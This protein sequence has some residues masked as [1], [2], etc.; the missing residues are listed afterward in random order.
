IFFSRDQH[1]GIVLE[2]EL[3]WRSDGSCFDARLTCNPII[4][5]E[6][7]IGA[8]IA[9]SDISVQKQMLAELSSMRIKQEAIINSTNDLIW[10]VDQNFQLITANKAFLER[11]EQYTGIRLKPGY[12]MLDFN[13]FPE[14]FI[15]FW[16]ELYERALKGEAFTE[17][18]Y[19][20]E[21]KN[22]PAT[23]ADI[24]FSPIRINDRITG[25][26]C[27]SRDMTA[28]KLYEKQILD[29]NSKLETAQQIAQLG[30]WELDL[31]RQTLYWSKEVYHIWGVNPENFEVNFD[32]F[33]QSIHPDDRIDFDIR[34]KAAMK[35]GEVLD[36][37]HRIILPDG[38]IRYVHEK[39]SL[40]FDDMDAPLKFEGTVQ[41]VTERVLAAAGIRDSEEKRKLIM[42]AALD[43]IVCIDMEGLVTFWNPQA[44][45]IFGWREEE[46]LGKLL[47][48]FIIPEKH[49]EAND[50]GVLRY[51][52]TGN[53][54]RINTI[55]ELSAVRKSGDEFPIELTVMPIQQ[56]HDE[57]FCAFIRDITDRKEF[58]QR[59]QESEE[60]YR[61]LFDNS[62]IPK[63]IYDLESLQIL[64]VNHAATKHY[65]YTK[66][67]FKGKNL[68]DL[69]PAEDIV[70]LEKTI[71]NTSTTG[72]IQFGQWRHLKANG[73]L[74]HVE[75]VGN[76]IPFKGKEAMLIAIMDI[77]DR[78]QALEKIQESEA[79]LAEAQRL[80]KLGSWNFD[81]IKDRLTWSDGLYHVFDVD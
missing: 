29:I 64:E 30:Y 73:E 56:E 75:V 55:L 78:K 63:W 70:L 32:N 4:D 34:Q 16:R 72:K 59:I 1:Q 7:S 12:D 47:S 39:G 58:L 10:S 23:W 76:I 11:I 36:F 81:F 26:A 21:G 38:G 66:E 41:D 53:G 79:S 51:S 71:R 74:I 25:T 42:N 3:L 9:F 49:R 80:A 2:D 31:N 60:K 50:Q 69:R 40:L 6:K 27:Y 44:E 65:G 62:P 46:V 17:E 24:H 20:P 77:T 52:K 45:K 19:T 33:Y 18:V 68:R 13:A 57:F 35:G 22:N 14:T 54:N 67:A 48:Q 43:A 15:L 61:N 28:Y 5:E 37:E 8:V